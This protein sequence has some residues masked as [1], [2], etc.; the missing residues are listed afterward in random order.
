[1][2]IEEPPVMQTTVSIPT[3]I[4]AGGPSEKNPNTKALN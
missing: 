1:M 3:G 2:D 4:V